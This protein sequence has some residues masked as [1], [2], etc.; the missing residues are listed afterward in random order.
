MHTSADVASVALLYLPPVRSREDTVTQENGAESC[1]CGMCR[2]RT[3]AWDRCARA[4]RAVVPRC[5]RPA[6]ERATRVLISPCLAL[7][8]RRLPPQRVEGPCATICRVTHGTYCAE[9][10]R[11]ASHALRLTCC[12]DSA[13]VR[14][15]F[16]RKWRA[17][18]QGAVVAQ[19]TDFARRRA[20]KLLKR[21][22]RTLA[23]RLLHLQVVVRTRAAIGRR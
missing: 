9:L 6:V 8:T 23:A 15:T 18:P 20:L 5:A 10:A 14:A 21:A 7:G 12:A 13:V 11:A 3:G 19:S 22:R 17:R 2:P 1:M 4:Q 16:A